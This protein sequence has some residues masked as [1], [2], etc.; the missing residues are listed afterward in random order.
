M[1]MWTPVFINN[2]IYL[3]AFGMVLGMLTWDLAFETRRLKTV[4]DIEM[5][6]FYY[7]GI[8]KARVPVSL[9]LPIALLFVFTNLIYHAV[10]NPSF[11]NFCALGLAV[12]GIVIEIV[13]A[14]PREI[15]LWKKMKV[16][17]E[18]EAAAID[19]MFGMIYTIR[20]THI[21]IYAMFLLAIYI[22]GGV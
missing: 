20:N 14:V 6:R 12:F 1:M 4:K 13:V 18:N 19:S 8:H 3:L 2:D 5:L 17:A 16:P 9:I 22:S 15:K 10:Q 11:V 21:A 7:Q